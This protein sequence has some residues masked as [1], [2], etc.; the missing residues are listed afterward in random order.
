MLGVKPH[1]VGAWAKAYKM[2][3]IKGLKEKK[4]GVK[5]EGRRLLNPVQE[6]QIRE[7]ILDTMPDQLKLPYG[8]WTRKAVKELIGRELGVAM[9][10][11]TT[12]DYLR[13]WGFTPQK[14]KKRAYGQGPE[15]V[16][17]WLEEEYP[18]IEKKAKD[19]NAEIHQRFFTPSSSY[20]YLNL[21][22][23]LKL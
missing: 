21:K 19:E 2:G 14:P 7:M 15:K 10:I 18:A 8:L 4:R 1:T 23:N 12:G 17:K 5:P 9:A 20:S 22:S 11:N 3:G 13:K 16:R 6:K